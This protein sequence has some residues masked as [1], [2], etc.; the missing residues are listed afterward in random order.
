MTS[1][2]FFPR[3][4]LY[5][6]IRA[7][8]QSV[9]LLSQQKL[10]FKITKCC[11]RRCLKMFSEFIIQ[12]FLLGWNI[13][14]QCWHTF[15]YFQVLITHSHIHCFPN[16]A[17]KVWKFIL[18]PQYNYKKKM[19]YCLDLMPSMCLYFSEIVCNLI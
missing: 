9:F 15:L 10:F 19:V 11:S 12:K 4:L 5:D 6:V 14:I 3:W 17:R 16:N 1:F 8:C 2:F 18:F 13:L 7:C